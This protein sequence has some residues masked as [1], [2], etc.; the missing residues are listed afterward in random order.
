MSRFTVCALA[1]AMLAGCGDDGGSGVD[2][3]LVN[4]TA[5]GLLDLILQVDGD[6]SGLD[7]DTLDGLDSTE[8]ARAGLRTESIQPG[9][10]NYSATVEGTLDDDGAAASFRW[11]IPADAR[12]GLPIEVTFAAAVISGTP[13]GLTFNPSALMF[14]AGTVS[15]INQ[16]VAIAGG[17]NVT[18]PVAGNTI[19]EFVMTISEMNAGDLSPGNWLIVNLARSG[20]D[21]ADTCTGSVHFAGIALEYQAQ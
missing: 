3:G 19:F 14:T 7:S 16:T 21:V 20:A 13:C 17:N 5:Q 4:P 2:G 15:P 6:G 18:T 8:F 10:L 11:R 1:L 9:A 12:A